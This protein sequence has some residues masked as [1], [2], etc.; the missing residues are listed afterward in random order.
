M[1]LREFATFQPSCDAPDL[2][3]P[4]GV[5]GWVI[6]LG[7]DCP[8]WFTSASEAADDWRDEDGWTDGTLWLCD[9]HRYDPHDFVQPDQPAGD[10]E[11]DRCHVARSEHEQ[12]D[13]SGS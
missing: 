10:P 13:D 6:E 8:Q 1:G 9:E 7:D 11:C 5:C 3:K 4:G 12:G 2:T